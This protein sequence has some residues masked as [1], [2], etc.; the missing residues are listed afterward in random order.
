MEL[1]TKCSHKKRRYKNSGLC[2]TCYNVELYWKNEKY[3]EKEQKNNRNRR[4]KKAGLDLNAP[5]YRGKNGTGW[6]DGSGYR[7]CTAHGHPNASKYKSHI[8]EHVLIMSNFLG[9]PLKKGETVHHINGIKDDNRIEN[10]ELW[11]KGHPPGQR[12]AQKIEWTIHFLEQYGY[13]C[14]KPPIMEES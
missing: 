10:L 1:C 8:A 3:R 7:R 13:T 9:R 2:S 4:R 6:I 11:H 14:Q 12:L 5:L